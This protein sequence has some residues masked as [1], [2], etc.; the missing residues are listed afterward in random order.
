M[1]RNFVVSG[2]FQ[3]IQI[4]Q[5]HNANKQA[6]IANK[7]AE[8]AN[9]LAEIAN[10]L[11]G[12]FVAFFAASVIHG[13]YVIRRHIIKVRHSALSTIFFQSLTHFAH[14]PKHQKLDV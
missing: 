12:L 11:I 6:E 5:A 1:V 3:I 14:F 2:P 4:F 13:I 8:I 7:L 10:I 9:K